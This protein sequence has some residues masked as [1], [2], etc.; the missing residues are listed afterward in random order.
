VVEEE[1][2]NVSKTK[3]I[4]TA[5]GS[6]GNSND[7]GVEFWAKSIEHRKYQIFIVGWRSYK[8]EFVNNF[9]DLLNII[10]AG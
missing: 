1:T 3:R 6:G 2:M 8:G 10:R 7:K 4:G 5:G 9:S